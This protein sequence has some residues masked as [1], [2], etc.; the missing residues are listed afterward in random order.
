MNMDMKLEYEFE[1]DTHFIN[2][3][4]DT[5]GCPVVTTLA[6]YLPTYLTATPRVSAKCD[7]TFISCGTR[8]L[9][10]ELYGFLQLTKTSVHLRATVR[11]L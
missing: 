3:L 1:F 10:A 8:Y 7:C 2:E 6:S 11:G 4:L 9:V 5:T